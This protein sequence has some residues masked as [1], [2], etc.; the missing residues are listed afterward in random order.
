MFFI[1]LGY[2]LIAI[3]DF[4]PLVRKRRKKDVAAWLVMFTLTLSITILMNL[5]I[6]VPSALKLIGDGLKAIGLSY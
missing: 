4:V 2:V 6:E 5:K 3:I 1:L